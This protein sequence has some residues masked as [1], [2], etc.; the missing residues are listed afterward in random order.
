M[1]IYDNYLEIGLGAGT[2]SELK[3]KQFVRNYAQFFPT[4]KNAH[5][6]DVGPGKGEMLTCLSRMGY[7]NLQGADISESVVSHI[8]SLGFEGVRTL[9]LVE[10]LQSKPNYFSM[11]TFCDVVEH[12][13]KDAIVSIMHAVRNS[14]S[15]DGVLIV[16]V[17]NMQ[18]IT[19]SI[20]RYDDFTHETGYTE[21]SLTQMLRLSGFNKI[22]CHGFDYLDNS[23]RSKIQ[24]ALRSLLWKCILGSRKI[25][26]TMPHRIQHPVLYAIVRK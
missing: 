21:R 12:I 22:E 9:N 18:S 4:D 7:T 10:Y 25:N 19:A 6:L 1:D 11:I 14:L 8:K 23:L 20:F 13:P 5:L 3:I 17:P 15:E 16:Q 2:L 26:G 24:S